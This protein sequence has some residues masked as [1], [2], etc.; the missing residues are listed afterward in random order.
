M[1][2]SYTTAKAG[3]VL[4][5]EIRDSIILRGETSTTGRPCS[6][7]CSRATELQQNTTKS[8]VL[9]EKYLSPTLKASIRE[10]HIA[11]LTW[12]FPKG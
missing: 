2:I 3:F 9:F 10:F 5:Q 12:R 7:P 11:F 6:I 4:P 8:D 1:K